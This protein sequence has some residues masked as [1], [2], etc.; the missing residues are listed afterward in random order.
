M[1][2]EEEE[3]RRLPGRCVTPEVGVHSWLTVCQGGL[4]AL[5]AL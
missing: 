5:G 4:E 1:E 3:E 2:E